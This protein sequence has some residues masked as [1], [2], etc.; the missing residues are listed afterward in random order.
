MFTVKL[1]WSLLW[2]V[3]CKWHVRCVFSANRAE[4]TNANT[5]QN[6]PGHLAERLSV[7]ATIIHE[8]YDSPL[9]WH[10]KKHIQVSVM[11]AARVPRFE[12]QHFRPRT[13]HYWDFLVKAEML[14]WL[15]CEDCFVNR[16]W[17]TTKPVSNHLQLLK[18]KFF[19]AGVVCHTA[20]C[21]QLFSG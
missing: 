11:D 16:N 5:G 8:C 9:A 12:C 2:L 6:K 4:K 7:T 15:K 17:V 19:F 18:K 3:T 13:S 10:Q 14:L 1:H 20:R 21:D